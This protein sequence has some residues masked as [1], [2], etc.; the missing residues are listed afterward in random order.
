PILVNS[1]TQFRTL[2][3]D[4]PSHGTNTF[5]M[6][7]GDYTQVPP[8]KRPRDNPMRY[9]RI[10]RTGT[11]T[12]AS[13]FV[14]L[15][16]PASNAVLSGQATVSVIATSALPVLSHKLYVDGL[17]MRESDDG[18]NYYFNTCEWAN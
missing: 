10:I 16:F 2:Y 12:A 1:N 9:Y 17:E 3:E 8:V 13:P 7:Y 15:T 18:T 6:D 11:N 4:Y 14:S 5:W